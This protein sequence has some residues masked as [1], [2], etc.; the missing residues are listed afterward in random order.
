MQDT[1]SIQFHTSKL[2]LGHAKLFS[3]A[4]KEPLI[5]KAS[6]LSFSEE[7]ERA[8]FELPVTLP[9]GSKAQLKIDFE[10]ELTG[11]MMGYYRSAWENEGK[12]EYYTLTQFEVRLQLKSFPLGRVLNRSLRLPTSPPPPDA[13]SHVGT[14]QL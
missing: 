4:L 7:D 8:T 10:A 3:E 13:P 12:T 5:Q 9:A 11:A 2:N 1:Q 14:S 6:E